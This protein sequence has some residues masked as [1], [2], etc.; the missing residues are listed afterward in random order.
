LQ[1]FKDEIMDDLDEFME[2][3]STNKALV[4]LPEQF[5]DV[6]DIVYDEKRD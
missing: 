3:V 5:D 1:T 4:K 6:V 2:E